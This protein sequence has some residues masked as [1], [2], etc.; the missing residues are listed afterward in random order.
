MLGFVRSWLGFPGTDKLKES[1]HGK[2][3]GF[4]QV[5]TFLPSPCWPWDLGQQKP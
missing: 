3:V 4:L 5:V 2:D 1:V